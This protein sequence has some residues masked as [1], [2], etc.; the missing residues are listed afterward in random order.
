VT[1]QGRRTDLTLGAIIMLT[2]IVPT[3]TE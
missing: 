2:I 3:M 1:P